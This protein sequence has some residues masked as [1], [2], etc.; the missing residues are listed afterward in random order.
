MKVIFFSESGF[1][2]NTKVKVL[3]K[4]KVVIN[5]KVLVNVE[6]LV[7]WKFDH[8]ALWEKSFNHPLLLN[9]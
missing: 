6:V 3:V 5:V 8:K 7:K 4:V 9:A 2:Y 1:F